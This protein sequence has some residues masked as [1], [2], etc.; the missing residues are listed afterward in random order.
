MADEGRSRLFC[1]DYQRA[2]ESSAEHELTG[3]DIVVSHAFSFA[4]Q[5]LRLAARKY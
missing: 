2:I 1:E 5:T 3:I 4:V